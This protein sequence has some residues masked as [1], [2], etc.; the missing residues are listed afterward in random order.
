MPIDPSRVQPFTLSSSN[1]DDSLW[2]RGQ[3]GPAHPA[4]V[5]RV[6][7]C[8][9]TW[10]C[11]MQCKARAPAPGRRQ[12]GTGARRRVALAG[13]AAACGRQNTRRGTGGPLGRGPRPVGF[14][15]IS[16]TTPRASRRSPLPAW[17]RVLC[18]PPGVSGPRRLNALPA[19]LRSPR[20][21]DGNRYRRSRRGSRGYRRRA[22]RAWPRH[23]ASSP[24]D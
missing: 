5:T 11:P 15:A 3:G 24:R 4:R 19:P 18:L 17:R 1:R 7:P 21:P 12:R 8:A 23:R 2:A 22:R 13:A 10:S 16:G 20:A 14:A 9:S 6:E